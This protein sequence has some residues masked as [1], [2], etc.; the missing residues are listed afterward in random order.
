[1][2]DLP[3]PEVR[4]VGT[5]SGI[6]HKR[7]EAIGDFFV[8]ASRYPISANVGQIVFGWLAYSA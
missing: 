4:V 1:L 2:L 3:E 5:H 7:L 8:E 6:R